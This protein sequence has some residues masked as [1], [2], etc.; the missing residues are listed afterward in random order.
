MTEEQRARINYLRTDLSIWEERRRRARWN[1]AADRL[2]NCSAMDKALG[3]MT[4]ELRQ[5]EEL[6]MQK[7]KWHCYCPAPNNIRTGP[8]LC[9]S[10]GRFPFL[11][12][13]TKKGKRRPRET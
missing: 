11:K 2:Y 7:K 1:L 5:L 12:E 6:E 13:V 10:C 4:A 9:P 3:E 8:G